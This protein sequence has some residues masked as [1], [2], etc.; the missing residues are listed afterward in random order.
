MFDKFTKYKM[1]MTVDKS[2][3]YN[4]LQ[5]HN[6]VASAPDLENLKRV[7]SYRNLNRI[8]FNSEDSL[9]GSFRDLM[10]GGEEID[11]NVVLIPIERYYPGEVL[12]KQKRDKCLQQIDKLDGS[13]LYEFAYKGL[14]LL[15]NCSELYPN[16]S[17]VLHLLTD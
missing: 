10:T 5:G 12:T 15:S 11:S 4:W 2:F 6:L 14:I 8:N 1:M 13:E 17:A 3:R 16:V 7:T 9:V